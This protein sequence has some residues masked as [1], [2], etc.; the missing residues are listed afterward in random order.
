[1]TAL[2][3]VLPAGVELRSLSESVSDDLANGAALADLLRDLAVDEVPLHRENLPR[4]R[5][6]LVAL[7]A[8]ASGASSVDDEMQHAAELLHLALQLHDLALGRPGGRRRRAV[9]RVVQGIGWVGGSV[10]T[11]RALEL[12]RATRPEA[13]ADVVDTLR[14]FTEGQ[15]LARELAAGRVP[16]RADWAEHADARTGALFAWCCRAGGVVARAP[17]GDR[18]ALARYGRHLGRLW[19]AAEDLAAQRHEAGAGRWLAQRVAI[20]RP[21]LPLVVALERDPTLEAGWPQ[22]AR[23]ERAAADRLAAAAIGPEVV[24]DVRDVLLAESFAARRALHVLPASPYRT[25]LEQL[26]LGVVRAG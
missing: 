5:P 22:V 25:A 9:R 3:E 23:G 8:R 4:I 10:L 18:L 12:V 13:L 11:L 20:G 26:T 14:E 15:A 1:M 16:R 2:D 6:I 7:A 21:V 17:S 24:S 19:H